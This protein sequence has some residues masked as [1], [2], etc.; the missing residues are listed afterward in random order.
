M[1]VPQGLTFQWIHVAGFFWSKRY[2]TGLELVKKQPVK[3]RMFQTGYK[4]VFR[5]L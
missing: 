4:G 2:E 1:P 3:V 5:T